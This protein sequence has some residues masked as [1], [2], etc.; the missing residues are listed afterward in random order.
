MSSSRSYFHLS[1]FC[2]IGRLKPCR[3]DNLRYYVM[4]NKIERLSPPL[5]LQLLME[6]KK[7]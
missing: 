2:G 1:T 6:E 5:K 7:S 3:N 4:V